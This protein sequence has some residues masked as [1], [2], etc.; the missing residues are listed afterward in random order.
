MSASVPVVTGEERT[1]PHEAI[2]ELLEHNQWVCFD[3]SKTPKQR[4]GANASSTDA[5]TWTSGLE[6]KEA[7]AARDELLGVGFVFTENDPYVGVDLDDAVEG[8]ELK[9]WARRIVEQLGSYTEFSPSGSGVHV[10]LR[11]RFDGSG[12]KC[13]YEDGAI[14][15]YQSAR[16]FTV[17]GKHV[18]GTPTELRDVDL[19]GF[20]A[21]YFPQQTIRREPLPTEQHRNDAADWIEDALEHVPA[22]DYYDWIKV[23]QGLKHEFGQQGFTF[24][25]RW[26]ATSDKYPGEQECWAKWQSF[27]GD[28]VTLGSVVKLAQDN[29]FEIPRR[30]RDAKDKRRLEL[31]G[32]QIADKWETEQDTSN[33]PEVE[34]PWLGAPAEFPR[35]TFTGVPLA[36]LEAVV[37]SS[38]TAYDYVGTA[39]LGLGAVAAQRGL[40][41]RGTSHETTTSVWALLVGSPSSK[42][43][44]AITGPQ[45][46]FYNWLGR[47]AVYEAEEG[48]EQKSFD[49][50]KGKDVAELKSKGKWPM[51][52]LDNATPEAARRLLSE[53]LAIVSTEGGRMLD[54]VSGMYAK[55]AGDPSVFIKAYDGDPLDVEARQTSPSGEAVSYPRL[56]MLLATHQGTIARMGSHLEEQGFW[57]RALI[58]KPLRP[59]GED[60]GGVD[61]RKQGH[62]PKEVESQWQR[63]VDA[64]L[65]YCAEAKDRDACTVL[66]LGD[67]ARELYLDA[68]QSYEDK[69]AR[70]EME[71]FYGHAHTHALRLAAV[72]WLYDQGFKR[73]PVIA[74][75]QMRRAIDLVDY[76]AAHFASVFGVE[77]SAQAIWYFIK[78]KAQK[79]EISK[80]SAQGGLPKTLRAKWKSGL[81]ELESLGAVRIETRDNNAKWIVL[82]PRVQDD[83][84]AE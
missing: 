33:W 79:G 2:L 80:R 84:G 52:L 16:Y 31:V 11:G 77:S 5:S 58:S 75:A 72:L 74:A 42:K 1:G 13:S 35:G 59:R 68:W 63:H 3:A 38:Q 56:S 36:M 39:L 49:D 76:Y 23:G 27:K 37:E 40:R 69:A 45:R 61:V 83:G 12:R 50:L 14:E 7:V 57:K 10:L 41:V 47:N 71:A 54:V 30:E 32:A 43:S 21:S 55:G 65:D 4:N 24:W 22:D 51:N 18:P 78:S 67:E 70:G 8:G 9:P 19:S 81:E 34:L 25:T 48:D 20:F 64:L 66:E 73:K 17:T 26:S 62:V 6:A 44:A 82:N 29:G 53:P 60:G 46:A 15:V 28:G